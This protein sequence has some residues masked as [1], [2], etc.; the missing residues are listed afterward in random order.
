MV[1]RRLSRL[2]LPQIDSNRAGRDFSVNME[3][4][5]YVTLAHSFSY[6]GVRIRSNFLCEWIEDHWL[7]RCAG[8]V[9]AACCCL[10][11]LCC[12]SLTMTSTS[13]DRIRK[14][15]PSQWSPDKI[16]WNLFDWTCKPSDKALHVPP[17]KCDISQQ[18]LY[19][20]LPCIN[21]RRRIED[22]WV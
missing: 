19:D 1:S 12:S 2:A 13:A 14:K 20:E 18:Q 15:R 3:M 7:K 21:K 16:D 5:D 9:F 22:Q 17:V 4:C 11:L 6:Y 10:F 8:A